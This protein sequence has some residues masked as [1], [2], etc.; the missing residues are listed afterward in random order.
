MAE[1][2]EV[3]KVNFSDLRTLIFSVKDY[4]IGISKEDLENIFKK[5]FRVEDQA[6]RFQGMGIGLYISNEIIKRHII[7]FLFPFRLLYANYPPFLWCF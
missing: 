6:M 7:F 4:G 2:L 3:G 1:T 5:Y